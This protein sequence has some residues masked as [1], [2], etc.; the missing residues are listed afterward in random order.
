MLSAMDPGGLVMPDGRGL[1]LQLDLP[2]KPEFV[3]IARLMIAS[4]ASGRRALSA[5]RVADL[6]LAVSEACTN[7]IESYGGAGADNRVWIGWRETP[8]ALEVWIRDAGKG[9]DPDRLMQPPPVT[10][11]ERLN[12]E[13]GLGIPLIRSLVD[14][15]D[16]YSSDL[17]TAVRMVVSC[18]PRG[19]GDQGTIGTASGTSVSRRCP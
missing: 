2:A 7:A 12:F 10:D 15:V 16:F 6:K 19:V 3:A 18:A 14:E 1:D 5:D 8:D 11:P 17:G 4:L 9:F 13:R